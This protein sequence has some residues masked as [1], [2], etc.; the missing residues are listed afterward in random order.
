[1]E[2]EELNEQKETEEV[3]EKGKIE[4][5]ITA[6]II[7]GVI[8]LAMIVCLIVILANGGVK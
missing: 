5:P 1:M 2:K 6:I 8:V 4:F 7:C 3:E